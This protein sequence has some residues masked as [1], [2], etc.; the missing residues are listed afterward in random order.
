MV[1][2]TEDTRFNVLGKEP[3]MYRPRNYNNGDTIPAL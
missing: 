2:D 1:V 3:S